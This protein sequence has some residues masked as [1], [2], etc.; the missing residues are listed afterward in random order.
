V[1]AA[2]QTMLP[3]EDRVAPVLQTGRLEATFSKKTPLFY[4]FILPAPLLNFFR[5]LFK[6]TPIFSKCVRN[7]TLA[8]RFR[9]LFLPY[10]FIK[11]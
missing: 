2:Y 5:R 8:V 7:R 1:Q 4:V 11:N 3:G 6:E 10:F 9:S